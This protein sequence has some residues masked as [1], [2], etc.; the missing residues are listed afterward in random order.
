MLKT[1]NKKLQNEMLTEINLKIL[2][3]KKLFKLNFSH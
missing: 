1:L 2:K 3:N